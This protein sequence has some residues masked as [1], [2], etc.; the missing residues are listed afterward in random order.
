MIVSLIASQGRRLYRRQLAVLA[1]ND[2]LCNRVKKD[3][4]DASQ[5]DRLPSHIPS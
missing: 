2:K 3:C 5:N 1:S 4:Y